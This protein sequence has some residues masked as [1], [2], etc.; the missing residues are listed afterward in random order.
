MRNGHLPVS[1]AVRCSCMRPYQA[2]VRE[3]IKDWGGGLCKAL[4]KRLVELTG[5]RNPAMKRC[6]ERLACHWELLCPQA[7]KPLPCQGPV[8]SIEGVEA[9]KSSH[10]GLRHTLSSPGLSLLAVKL[11]F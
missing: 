11:A 9:N 8:D 4:G 1:K 6:Q 7:P 10:A 2:L 5:A 3:R